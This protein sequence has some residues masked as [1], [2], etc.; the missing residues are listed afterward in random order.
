MATKMD[1]IK[2]LADAGRVLREY[3][4]TFP[5]PEQLFIEERP[6]GQLSGMKLIAYI[7]RLHFDIGVHIPSEGGFFRFEYWNGKTS[8][9]L[10]TP[11][12]REGISLEM[13]LRVRS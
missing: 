11:L 2:Y 1:E 6:I 5:V 7:P 10:N 4:E 13:Q 8:H 12:P 9:R 3:V